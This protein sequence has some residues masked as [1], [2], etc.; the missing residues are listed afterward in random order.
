MYIQ[1][2]NKF[3]V[4]NHFSEKSLDVDRARSWTSD[5]RFRTTYRDMSFKVRFQRCNHIAVCCAEKQRTD[6]WVPRLRARPGYWRFSRQDLWKDL[7]RVSY[8]SSG[9]QRD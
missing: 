5:N 7:K 3:A 2:R 9:P 6:S 1:Q 4:T 8:D